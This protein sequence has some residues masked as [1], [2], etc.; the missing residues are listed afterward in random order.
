MLRAHLF[1]LSLVSSLPILSPDTSN[2]KWNLVR[3][4]VIFLMIHIFLVRFTGVKYHDGAENKLF[5]FNEKYAYPDAHKMT[6]LWPFVGKK[7]VPDEI[8]FVCLQV[9]FNCQ[10]WKFRTL[11][12]HCTHPLNSPMCQQDPGLYLLLCTKAAV[13]AFMQLPVMGSF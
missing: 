1:S 12:H 8:H 5:H 4:Y 10:M 9:S 3:H 6:L 2:C 11:G 7:K 13:G